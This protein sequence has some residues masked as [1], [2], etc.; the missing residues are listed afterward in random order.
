MNE[1]HERRGHE[2]IHVQREGREFNH[3]RIEEGVVMKGERGMSE[4]RDYYER[5]G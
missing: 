3:A 5:R 4:R 2:N 1:G